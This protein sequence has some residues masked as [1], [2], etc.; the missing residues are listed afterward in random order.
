M[1]KLRILSYA[2][3]LLVSLVAAGSAW[4]ASAMGEPK[5][6]IVASNYP[7][8]YFA[9]RLAGPRATVT[10]PPPANVD[11]AYW[12][13]DAKAVGAMQKA[14]LIL[15]NGADYEK[16]LA[17]VALPRL[18]Q[19]DTSATFRDRYIRIENAVVHSH[20]PAGQHSHEGIAFT[21][22]LDFDQAAQQAEAVANALIAKRPELKALTLDSLKTLQQDLA[23]LDGEI[24]RIT[25]AKPSLPLMASHPVYQYLARRYSL[26]LKSVHWEPGEMPPAREWAELDKTLASHPA[27]AMLW[28]SEPDAQV[29]EKLKAKGIASKVFDPCANR[30]ETGDFLTVMQQNIKN[31]KL[32]LHP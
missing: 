8:A 2:A 31:L 23:A 30:P 15:L 26:N 20:G 3:T 5:L 14:D 7:L 10:L 22:W 25:A 11:P 27:K 16:W 9:E 24:Q 19:V 13:P 21:T 28:E 17:H 32:V 12:Q 1:H 4:G 6:K 18:K 29:V